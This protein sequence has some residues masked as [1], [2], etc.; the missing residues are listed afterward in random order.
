MLLQECP[1]VHHQWAIIDFALFSLG[2]C[3]RRRDAGQVSAC[4]CC[5][6]PWVAILNHMMPL[7]AS[8]SV[9]WMLAARLLRTKASTP[10]KPL[11]VCASASAHRPG[12]HVHIKCS[13]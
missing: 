10:L 6:V 2:E 7:A 13:C 3:S 9:N 4:T 5:A 11:H 12:Q 8:A 1:W